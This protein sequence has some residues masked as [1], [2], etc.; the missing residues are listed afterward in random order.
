MISEQKH[1]ELQCPCDKS[2]DDKKIVEYDFGLLGNK[3]I[4]VCD[5]CLK[6]TPY[7]QFIA[8][9]EDPEN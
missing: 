5:S 1:A 2:L 8:N 3:V 6:V 4:K 9:I 7:N